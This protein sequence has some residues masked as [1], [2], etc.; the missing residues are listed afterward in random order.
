VRTNVIAVAVR[1]ATQLIKAVVDDDILARYQALHFERVLSGHLV[2]VVQPEVDGI[3]HEVVLH[4]A[5]LPP[6]EQ[7]RG[8]EV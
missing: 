4:R 2:Q 1:N 8:A 3:S 5:A 7:P 6:Q